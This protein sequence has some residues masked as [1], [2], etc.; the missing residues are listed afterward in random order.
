MCMLTKV[1]WKQTHDVS[2]TS[3]EL[4]LIFSF[5]VLLYVAD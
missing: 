2:V 1:E 5:L 3:H 4:E